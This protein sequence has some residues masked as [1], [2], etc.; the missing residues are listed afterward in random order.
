MD[1][2]VLEGAVDFPDFLIIG[3][4]KCGTTTLYKW[5]DGHPGV[6]IPG[7]ELCFFSQDIFPTGKLATHIPDLD[8][9]RALFSVTEATGKTKGEATPK[10][11]YSDKALNALA[12]MNPRP[13]LIVCVRDPVDLAISLH[14]QKVREG[15]EK[16]RDFAKAWMRELDVTTPEAARARPGELN[17][18]FWAHIGARLERLFSLF[19][20]EDVLIIHLCELRQRPSEVYE[21][22]LRFLN[23]PDDG[24]RLFPSSNRRTGLRSPRINHWALQAK[25]LAEPALGPLRRARGGRGLGL[26]KMINRYNVVENTYISTISPGLREQLVEFLASDIELAERHLAGPLMEQASDDQ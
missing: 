5:V 10:Y 23:L 15:W 18:V 9:Y 19:R 20:T 8:A 26:L 22:L 1:N 16:E 12:N 7:K 13:R 25:R 4:P 14:S 17:Y 3:A 24:R 21:R 2:G 6:F 11:L